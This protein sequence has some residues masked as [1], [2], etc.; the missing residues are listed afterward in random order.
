MEFTDWYNVSSVYEPKSVMHYSS[1]AGAN[2]GENPVG[3]FKD[4]SLFS[5]GYSKITTTDALQLQTQYCKDPTDA[6]GRKWFPKF[7]HSDTTKCTSEDEVGHLRDVF[8]NRLCDGFEDCPNGED[9]GE[10]AEC[11]ETHPRTTDGCCGGVLLKWLESPCVFNPNST[12]NY[13]SENPVWECP[14]GDVLTTYDRSTGRRWIKLK[15]EFY[16]YEGG[17]FSWS[18]VLDFNSTCPPIGETMEYGRELSCGIS[19]IVQTNFCASNDC[20]EHATC[21]NRFDSSL[22]ICNENY[23]GDGKTCTFDEPV[24]E[25]FDGTH[26]CGANADCIDTRNSYECECKAGYVN[27]A[28]YVGSEDEDL[29]GESCTFLNACCD[30]IKLLYSSGSILRHSC[31]KNGTFNEA[32]RYTCDGRDD[33]EI[34]FGLTDGSWNCV[35][36]SF[37]QNNSCR[38]TCDYG[39]STGARAKC[40][41]KTKGTWRL[42]NETAKQT[43]AN[44]SLCADVPAALTPE[45]GEWDCKSY[46][47]KRVCQLRCPDR[48]RTVFAD[49][50]VAKNQAFAINDQKTHEINSCEPVVGPCDISNIAEN[51]PKDDEKWNEIDFL[52]DFDFS[53]THENSNILLWGRKKCNSGSEFHPVTEIMCKINKN[54]VVWKFKGRNPGKKCPGDN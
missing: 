40:L 42:P 12:F 38:W 36:S 33:Y 51:A 50:T 13:K 31:V 44:C 7:I 19:G 2:Q 20:H 11:A 28:R 3:T 48:K 54:G 32:T 30:D 41:S 8:S 47:T 9:E 24:D 4:G 26:S 53:A 52:Q 10:I 25:C 45:N 22:C 35:G 14:D 18:D 16:P 21:E 49:C 15:K 27:N 1:F 43:K 39:V 5:G 46:I 37:E 23:S 17:G 6:R 29:F 34:S